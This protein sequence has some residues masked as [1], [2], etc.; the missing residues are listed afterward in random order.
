MMAAEG[1][2]RQ[3]FGERFARAWSVFLDRRVLIVLLL[4]F[5]SGLPLALSGS[6]L[7]LWMKDVGVDLGT[8]GLFALVGVPY[9]IKFL[10]APIVDAFQV[11][12]VGPR[13]RPSA[14]LARPVPAPAHGGDRLSRLSEP[15]RRTVDGG[16]RRGGGGDGLGHAG[17]RHRRLPRRISADRRA[18]RGHGLFRRRLPHRHARLDRGRR[19]ARGLSRIC[20]RRSEARLGLWLRR[21]GRARAHRHGGGAHG[22]GAAGTRARGGSRSARRA[23]GQSAVALLPRGLCRLRR[24][25][26]RNATR[27]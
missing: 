5:S 1:T 14:R 4:G 24:F 19:R 11:P 21:H 12:V 23:A 20:R 3:S 15:A 18:G 16:A 26:R 22:A 27:C 13:A 25:P 10:W 7:L 9:T 6:T 17:H 2:R 8:I